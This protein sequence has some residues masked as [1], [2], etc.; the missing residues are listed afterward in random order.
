VDTPMHA[1]FDRTT[2]VRREFDASAPA[3]D[4]DRARSTSFQKQQEFA[5][6]WLGRPL[7]CMLEIGCGAGH[8]LARLGR[9]TRRLV[10]VDLSQEM[11]RV[12]RPRVPTNAWRVQADGCR[13]PFADASFDGALCMGFLEYAPAE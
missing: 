5:L 7:E 8:T 6:R 1:A 12:A 11:L 13:L 9:H 3:Y 4:E 2:A 10:A